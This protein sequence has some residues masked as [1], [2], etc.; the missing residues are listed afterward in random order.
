[1]ALPSNNR[2]DQSQSNNINSHQPSVQVSGSYLNITLTASS[3]FM[4]DKCNLHINLLSSGK[5]SNE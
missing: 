4:G 1:M 5:N 2:Q 3:C